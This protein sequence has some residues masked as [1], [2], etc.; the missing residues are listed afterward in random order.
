MGVLTPS[1]LMPT[2]L[3]VASPKFSTSNRKPKKTKHGTISNLKKIKAKELKN[4][5]ICLKQVHME[6]EIP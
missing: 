4:K 6:V 5:G 1:T 2:S 3:G